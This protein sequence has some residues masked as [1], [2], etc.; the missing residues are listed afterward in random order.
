MNSVS[1]SVTNKMSK[2]LKEELRKISSR[3]RIKLSMDNVVLSM[4]ELFSLT[5]NYLKGDSNVFKAH[6]EEHYLDS[7]LFHILNAKGNR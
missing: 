1:K 4:C 3:L 5:T 7:L 2:E 6:M